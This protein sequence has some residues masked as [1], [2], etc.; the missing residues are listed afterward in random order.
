LN[1]IESDRFLFLRRERISM[2]KE[3]KRGSE[4]IFVGILILG[5][6]LGVLIDNLIVGLALGFGLAFIAYGV[7]YLKKPF[8]K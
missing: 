8:K 5:W 2:K 4:M 7:L 6:A 3:K 1:N